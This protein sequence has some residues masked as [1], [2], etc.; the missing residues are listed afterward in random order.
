MAETIRTR[1][2]APLAQS[3]LADRATAWIAGTEGTYRQ[4]VTATAQD[5]RQIEQTA[6]THQAAFNRAHLRHVVAATEFRRVEADLRAQALA[7]GV[8]ANQVEQWVR[9][10]PAY[11]EPQARAAETLQARDQHLA[12]L[13]KAELARLDKLTAYESMLRDYTQ[14]AP[15]RAAAWAHTDRARP[16]GGLRK[17]IGYRH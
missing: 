10:Q 1:L 3:A 5:T 17:R 16:G 7:N 4:A 6:Q 2:P 8:P 13:Q 9:L 12:D 11:R 14:Y 15:E